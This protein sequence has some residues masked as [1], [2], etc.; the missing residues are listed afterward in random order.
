MIDEK[1]EEVFYQHTLRDVVS[2]MEQ[3][4]YVQV[5]QDIV[6]ILSQRNIER[7]VDNTDKQE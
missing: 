1:L 7:S 4:G 3:H 6:T 5:L 2:L